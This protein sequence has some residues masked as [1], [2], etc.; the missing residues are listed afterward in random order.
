MISWQQ[1]SWKDGGLIITRKTREVFGVSRVMDIFLPA[2]RGR[3]LT[4]GLL[5]GVCVMSPLD[6]TE[7]SPN[8]PAVDEIRCLKCSSQCGG[9]RW[10]VF[11]WWAHRCSKTESHELKLPAACHSNNKPAVI[12]IDCNIIVFLAASESNA[13]MNLCLIPYFAFFRPDIDSLDEMGSSCSVCWELFWARL[14][15]TS[16]YV[17]VFQPNAYLNTL[18]SITLRICY[19]SDSHFQKIHETN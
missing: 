4:C 12:M 10:V 17:C 6:W 9:C 13:E 3:D 15:L 7:A 19:Y 8:L 16:I 5:S 18:V 14:A 1:C 2:C 11:V